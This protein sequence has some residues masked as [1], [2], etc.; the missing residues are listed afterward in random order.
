MEGLLQA[1]KFPDAAK[2][3]RVCELVGR[4]AKRAGGR[5][6]WRESWLLHWQGLSLDREGVHY[7]AF[8]DEAYDALFVESHRARAALLATGESPLTHSTGSDD[9]SETILTATE[10]CDRLTRIRARMSRSVG[11]P[12]G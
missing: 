4:E 8:L 5:V 12:G 2:Q 10:F 11:R 3:R 6:E 9:P 7:Q 1:L